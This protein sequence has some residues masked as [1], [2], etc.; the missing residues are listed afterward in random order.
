MTKKEWQ[1]QTQRRILANQLVIMKALLHLNVAHG[2]TL[3]AGAT[4]DELKLAINA[5]AGFFSENSD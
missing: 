3:G 5:S 2:D 1:E 4:R